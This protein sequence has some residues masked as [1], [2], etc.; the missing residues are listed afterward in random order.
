MESAA[1]FSPLAVIV[2]MM[3]IA[4]YVAPLGVRRLVVSLFRVV[5]VSVVV[6]VAVVV[7]FVVVVSVSAVVVIV[8]QS[9]YFLCYV[10]SEVAV[11]VLSFDEGL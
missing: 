7:V 3:V 9:R 5:V 1:L 6:V 11:S 2:V 10:R 8:V 4:R